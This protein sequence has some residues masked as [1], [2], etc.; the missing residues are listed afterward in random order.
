MSPSKKDIRW[1]RSDVLKNQVSLPVFVWEH[2]SKHAY[3][4]TPATEEHIYQTIVDPDHV[5]RSLDHITSG[6]SCVFEKFFQQEQ[7]RFFVPVLYDGIVVPEEYESGGKKGR[8]LTGYFPG[9]TN[10]SKTV[11]AIFWSK[12]K[13]VDGEG[14][15]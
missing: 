4:K 5:R 2:A 11:G 3:D 6:E 7:Q 9:R 8:V 13:P 14:S 10:N 15:K 12:Q 1:V